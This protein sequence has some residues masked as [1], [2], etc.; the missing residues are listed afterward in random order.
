ME[1]KV[2]RKAWEKNT[3]GLPTCGCGTK[4]GVDLTDEGNEEEES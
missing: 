3:N 2:N 4:M 1:Y